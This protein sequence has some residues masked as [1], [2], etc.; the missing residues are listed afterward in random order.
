MIPAPA[1]PARIRTLIR[2]EKLGA[3][4]LANRKTASSAKATRIIRL[5]PMASPTGPKSGWEK[6]KGKV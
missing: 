4:A 3:K 2:V 1:M 6:L 5:L